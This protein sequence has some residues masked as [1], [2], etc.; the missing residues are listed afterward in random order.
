M[1]NSL[2][3]DQKDKLNRRKNGI[4]AI[5]NLLD[6]MERLLEEIKHEYLDEHGEKIN[7][8]LIADKDF[9]KADE[10]WEGYKE[11][12]LDLVNEH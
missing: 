12:L 2:S 8:W 1:S 10:Q 11:K 7:P 4:N 6:T 3:D 9:L 5:R